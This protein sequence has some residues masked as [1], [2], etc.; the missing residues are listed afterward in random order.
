M[1]KPNFPSDIPCQCYPPSLGCVC[2]NEERALRAYAHHYVPCE[3]MNHDTR[4]WCLSEIDS[5][6]GYNRKEYE[7]VSD[8]RLAATV[9]SAWAD[10][11]RDKGLL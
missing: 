6:E 3:P 5:V 8:G 10:Y 9:L 7:S 11:A 2:S 4:A 1:T